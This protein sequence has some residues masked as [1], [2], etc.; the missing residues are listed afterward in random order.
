MHILIVRPGAIGDTLLTFPVLQVLRSHYPDPQIIFVGNAAVLSLALSAGLVEEISDYE[1]PQWSQLFS[2]VGITLPTLRKRLR[3]TDLAI[4]WLGDPDGRVEQNVLL[5]GVKRVLVAPGRPAQER[6]IHVVEH[7]LATLGLQQAAVIDHKS[8][9]HLLFPKQHS[10]TLQRCVAIHPGSG[11]PQKCWPIPNFAAIIAYLWSRD[12][13]VLLLGGPADSE[14]IATLLQHLSPPSP[15]LLKVLLNA[16]LAE[17]A[18]M[19]QSCHCF[20]G[21]D[22]GITHL[23]ALLGVPTIALFGP[24]SDPVIWR[25]MGS[26]VKVIEF[27]VLEWLSV[28]VYAVMKA[29]EALMKL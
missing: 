9:P 23:A 25:P 17:V 8:S 1:D 28:D 27:S 16:P 24:S 12:I 26:S 7:L 14:R 15:E 20:V 3:Q 21:N 29:L 2:T 5:A 10:S 4:C 19:L 18:Q 11:G 13:P 6:G 22:S